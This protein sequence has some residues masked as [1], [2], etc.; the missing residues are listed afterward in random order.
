MRGVERGDFGGAAEFGEKAA[1]GIAVE[2]QRRHPPG[3]LRA[4]LAAAAGDDDAP[5]I[6]Q[7]QRAG[8]PG[9]GDLADAV[10]EIAA[11]GDAG[12]AQCFDDADL[13]REQQRLGNVGA[14]HPV[15]VDAAGNL[16]GDRPAERRAQ[17]GVDGLDRG[18]EGPAGA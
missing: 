6:G 14:R 16:F 18:A 9:G 12:L 1:R 17:H 13:D 4:L 15:G 8:G 5:G 10:P 7:G 11:S 3:A 2:R